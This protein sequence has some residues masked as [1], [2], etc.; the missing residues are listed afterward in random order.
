[1]NR[2]T[3][4]RTDGSYGLGV[5]W[6]YASMD[7]RRIPHYK[8]ALIIASELFFQYGGSARS[9]VRECNLRTCDAVHPSWPFSKFLR[10]K[11]WESLTIIFLDINRLYFSG[12]HLSD[13]KFQYWFIWPWRTWEWLEK[14]LR[15]NVLFLVC[16]TKKK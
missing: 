2:K 11:L 4:E 3:T 13:F 1:M 5:I 7:S 6:A 10:A 14:F 9:H 8:F 15:G 16:C 12:N